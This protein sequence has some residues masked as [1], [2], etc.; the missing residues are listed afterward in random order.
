MVNEIWKYIVGHEGRYEV[1]NLGRIR[2]VDR[3]VPNKRWHESGTRLYRSKIRSQT[4]TGDGGYMGVCIH[5]AKQCYKRTI[6]KTHIAVLEAF[7]GPRPDGMDG[8]HNDGDVTNN[9]LDNLRW[10]TPKNNNSDK[11]KHGTAQVGSKNPSAKLN[12]YDVAR[13]KSM[14]GKKS[15]VTISKEFGVS[16][17]TIWLIKNGAKWAHVSSI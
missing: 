8:C 13:I 16:V 10:D 14:I 5:D 4:P 12:E 11:I 17:T 1:S 9:T 2:S 7:V 6:V 3:I 15:M